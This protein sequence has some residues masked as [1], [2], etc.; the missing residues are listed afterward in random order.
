MAGGIGL[1][2]DSTRRALVRTSQKIL[3]GRSPEKYSGLRRPSR[4]GELAAAS[5]VYDE[6]PAARGALDPAPSSRGRS[7]P[8]RVLDNADDFI[9]GPRL[10]VIVTGRTADLFCRRAT[11]AESR[12]A[13][14]PESCG[15]ASAKAPQA[16]RDVKV[17]K[18]LTLYCSSASL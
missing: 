9:E 17:Q 2:Q 4:M 11:L 6:R 12:H 7:V 18:I 13:G 16:I 1:P 14:R 10:F 15:E 5:R 8:K 3:L